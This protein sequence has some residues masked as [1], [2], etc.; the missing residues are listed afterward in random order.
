MEILY[1]IV[2]GIT[3]GWLGKMGFDEF[4]VKQKLKKDSLKP[5]EIDLNFVLWEIGDDVSYPN[6]AYDHFSKPVIVDGVYKG[7]IDN[8]LCFIR[9]RK[10]EQR[11]SSRLPQCTNHSLLKRKL[12]NMED[13]RYYMFLKLYR[14]EMS[15]E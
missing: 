1:Y 8:H 3:L 5:H 2:I 13:D 12:N 14:E 15:D 4:N 7:F 9:N 10:I 11:A 6:P